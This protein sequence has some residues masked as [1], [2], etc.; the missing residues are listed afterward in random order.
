MQ[1]DHPK[2]EEILQV[3]EEVSKIPRCSKNEQKI[4]QWLMDWAAEHGFEAK[5]DKVKNVVIK[6]PASAGYENAAGVILQGHM[7]MVCEKTKTSTHDFGKDPIK[8]VYDGDWLTA[9]ETTLGADNGI[10]IAMA[11]ALA[12]DDKVVHP[13]LELL[14]TVDEET[15]LTG[16]SALEPGFLEG[17]ILLNVDSEDEGIFTVGCAGGKDTHMWVPFETAA[18]PQDAEGFK[19]VAGGMKG[20]HSGVDIHE[21]RA[22]AI[23]VLA[24]ALHVL[25]RD[26]DIRLVSLEGGTAHNAI[27]RDAEAVLFVPAD[28]VEDA[29]SAVQ[30]LSKQVQSEYGKVDP[31]LNLAL[32][33]FADADSQRAMSKK[34]TRKVLDFIQTVP[35]GVAFMSN[36]IAGLVET[37]NNLATLA[38]EGD[39]IHV[40]TSQRSSVMERMFW[41][42]ERIEGICRL[43]GGTYESG[44]GY[45]SWE[46]DMDSP[47]LQKCKD[48]YKKLFDKEPVVEIIHAGLECGIIGS[49]YPGMDMI[50]FG[51]TIKNPH[52]PD[53]M[54][55]LPTVGMVWDFTVALLETLK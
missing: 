42:T 23:H 21:Q 9:D 10:A 3:F 47:L 6:V 36:D 2:T 37:S 25:L 31:K 34:S 40:S 39:K 45:P 7:D 33:P 27:P 44:S 46:P 11:L 19:L 8:F 41:L 32:D 53:E 4:G 50:S 54:L 26:Y 48:V 43:A 16:A 49:K 13:P 17:K 30:K 55:E 20:G 51:P 18:A 12:T 52:S 38:T 28:A 22:N 14:F 35:H 15:G 24:R 29:K 1:F 5:Q